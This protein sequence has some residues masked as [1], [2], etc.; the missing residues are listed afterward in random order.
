MSFKFP[1]TNYHELNLDWILDEITSLSELEDRFQELYDELVS[2]FS[3]IE[4]TI[5]DNYTEL[6]A[7]DVTLQSNIDALRLEV[8]GELDEIKTYTDSLVEDV[9]NELVTD[10]SDKISALTTKVEE[11][12]ITLNRYIVEAIEECKDYTDEKLEDGLSNISVINYF[13]GERITIQE[14]LNYLSQFHVSESARYENIINDNIT[15]DELQT[16]T[17]EFLIKYGTHGS[18][19]STV[20]GSYTYEPNDENL[21]IDFTIGG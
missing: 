2:E 21:I 3:T 15:Y 7:A 8:V 18:T 20:E 9:R 12:Y 5:S 14:M 10:Y 16:F 19:D 1:Y 13:T 11:Y 6:K 17:Y 4:Q